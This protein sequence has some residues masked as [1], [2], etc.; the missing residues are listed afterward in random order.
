MSKFA[1]VERLNPLAIHGLF[2]SRERADRHLSEV[3]P[4]YVERRY[5]SDKTLR[6][7]DFIVT[8]YKP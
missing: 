6:P 4:V 5:F 1:V 3:I 8:E 7:E 2:D